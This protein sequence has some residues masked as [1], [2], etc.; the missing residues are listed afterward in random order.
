MGRQITAPL[1]ASSEVSYLMVPV[2]LNT[3]NRVDRKFD[4]HSRSHPKRRRNTITSRVCKPKE[5]WPTAH[6]NAWRHMSPQWQL[7]KPFAITTSTQLAANKRRCA[8]RPNLA[9]ATDD[10]VYPHTH[11][12]Q[13]L[14]AGL[15]IESINS[16]RNQMPW[17]DRMLAANKMH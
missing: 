13:Q 2:K 9:T 10:T 7:I 1:Q 17:I 5:F 3:A 16:R 12:A 4:R 15:I 6:S 8:R 11:Q 14:S